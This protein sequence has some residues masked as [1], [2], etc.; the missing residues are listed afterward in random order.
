MIAMH[1]TCEEMWESLKDHHMQEFTGLLHKSLPPQSILLLV[2][3]NYFINIV[4]ITIIIRNFIISG[5][6]G[7]G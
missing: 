6:E 4:L 7:V 1:A 5:G 3:V 2:V